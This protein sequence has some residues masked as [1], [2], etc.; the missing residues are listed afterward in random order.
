MKAVSYV[1]LLI[2]SGYL[3]SNLFVL[4]PA[5]KDYQAGIWFATF[6]ILTLSYRRAKEIIIPL[7]NFSSLKKPVS[8]V[9]I[10]LTLTASYF[11]FLL[12]IHYEIL[13]NKTYIFYFKNGLMTGEDV[14]GII[15]K[16]LLAPIW[17][18]LFF[19]GILLFFLLRYVKPIW[20]ISISAIIFAMF[21]PMYWI[22]TL[23][24]GL[25]LAFT[26]YKTKSFIPSL[27]SHS[28]WNLYI[29][30]LFIYF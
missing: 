26:T 20:A 2:L 16:V 1:I 15:P 13:L 11:L 25:L 12:C 27:L 17:E 3:I 21:H 6:L 23:I 30:K 5:L 28:L 18:E 14:W 19:R 7:V 10:F 24:S 9:Y 8:Y 4:N 29:S 22:L